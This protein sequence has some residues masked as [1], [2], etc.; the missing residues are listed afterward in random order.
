MLANKIRQPA[1]GLTHLAGAASAL[2]GQ[3]VLLI[4]SGSQLVDRISL[5][6]YG[7][8]LFGLFMASGLYHSI[9]STPKVIDVLRKFDHAAIYLLIAGTYTPFCLMAFHGFWKWGLLTIIW[10]LAVVGI[11]TNI[12][13]IKAPRWITAGVYVLMGWLVALAFR[14]MLSSLALATIRWLF[15]G[16]IIYTLG[17]VVYSTKRLD[18]KPNVFGFH[19]VWHIF[20]MLGAAAHF[21]A[22]YS[23]L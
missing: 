3:V 23:L 1:S 6:I 7:A 11:I 15:A 10:L 20:V 19:E 13:M 16:G 5:L 14:E 21:F 4:H 12:W 18:F 2:I 17:A 8:S 9:C 22:V